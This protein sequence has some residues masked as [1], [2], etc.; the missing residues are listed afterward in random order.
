MYSSC[1]VLVPLELRR[2]G[3]GYLFGD[4]VLVDFA[5]HPLEPSRDGGQ[6]G[7]PHRLVEDPLAVSVQGQERETEVVEHTLL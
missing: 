6:L 1:M 3:T 4:D 5:L 2:R 7:G